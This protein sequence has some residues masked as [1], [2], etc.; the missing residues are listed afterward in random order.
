MHINVCS[1]YFLMR[2]SITLTLTGDFTNFL[3]VFGRSQPLWMGST[4]TVGPS[5]V[6]S[7]SS[8][9]IVSLS[10]GLIQ[11]VPYPESVLS[12]TLSAAYER[13]NFLSYTPIFVKLKAIL[14]MHIFTYFDLRNVE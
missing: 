8:L 13:F 12:P 6:V 5:R 9:P 3:G 11:C 7:R 4:L 10:G 14:Y 2:P 1:L